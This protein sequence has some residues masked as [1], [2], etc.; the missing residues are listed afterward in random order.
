MR[1]A[2]SWHGFTRTDSSSESTL[3]IGKP[4]WIVRDG[5]LRKGN[6]PHGNDIQIKNWMLRYEG[7]TDTQTSK[8]VDFNFC[9]Q[10]EWGEFYLRTFSPER[11]VEPALVHA[12]IFD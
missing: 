11:D 4:Y 10:P 5:W 1:L 3:N 7:T 9:I 12:Y 2:R 6:D 8:P